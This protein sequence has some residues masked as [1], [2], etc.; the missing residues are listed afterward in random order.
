MAY[1]PIKTI[2]LSNVTVNTTT[3]IPAGYC[4]TNLVIQNTTAN[5]VTGGLR[6]GTI[7]GGADVV[8]NAA[9]IGDSLFAITDALLLKR[10]F[11]MVSDTTL[12]IQTI[13]LWNNANIKLFISLIKIN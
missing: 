11:S 8:L 5:D 4:I 6:I 7:D 3:V 1:L 9:V 12:Y 2:T 13:A 10:I